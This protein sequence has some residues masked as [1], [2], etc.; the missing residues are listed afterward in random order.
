LRIIR[1]KAFDPVTLVRSPT[2]TNSDSSSM[3]KGSSPD[4]RVATGMTG[5]TRGVTSDTAFA[6]ASMCG[7]VVPQQPPATLTRPATANS[8][9]SAEVMS[10]VSSKPV[11]AIGLGRPALG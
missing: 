11:S 8:R 5:G 10:G 1:A 3:L 2:L 4:R 7:G 6:M 9:I